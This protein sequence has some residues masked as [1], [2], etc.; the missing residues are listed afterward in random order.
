MMPLHP[1]TALLLCRGSSTA[2]VEWAHEEIRGGYKTKAET[3]IGGMT[4]ASAVTI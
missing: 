4:S 3:R 2:G 1:T